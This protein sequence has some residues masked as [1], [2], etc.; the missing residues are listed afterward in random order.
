MQ[1]QLGVIYKDFAEWKRDFALRQEPLSDGIVGPVTL[2][3]LQRFG[4]NFKINTEGDYANAFADNI[5]RIA[6]FG[7]RHKSELQLLVSPEFESWDSSQPEKIKAKDY[8]IRRQG[9]DGELIDLVNRFR[10]SRKTA[11]RVALNRNVDESAYF[12]YS[13]NQADLE[14]L[15]SKDQV[16]QIL[17]TLKDKEFNSTEALRIAVSQAMGGAIIFC[18]NSGL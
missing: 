3:W 6:A 8:Q 16:V 15:G 12:T 2:S 5:N 18:A 1:K 14:V 13:L 4:F 9:N 17:S 11:P 10:G 7:E